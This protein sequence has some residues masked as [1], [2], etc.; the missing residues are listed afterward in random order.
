MTLS[1][2]EHTALTSR[3][4]HGAME[5]HSY[6]GPGLLENAYEEALY[7]ELVDGGM[8]VQR[9]SLHPVVYKSHVIPNAYRLDLIVNDVVVVEIKA[10]EK[11][12]AL[13]KSQVL[14]YLKITNRHIGLLFNFNT[15]HMRDGIFRISL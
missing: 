14:T 11:V 7:W 13:H 4:I 2:P 1:Y 9:Q 3:I 12:I 10:V 5:V 6:F 8:V 15:E